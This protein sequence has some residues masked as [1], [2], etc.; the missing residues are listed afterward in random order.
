M[1]G[2]CSMSITVGYENPIKCCLL[3][4]VAREYDSRDT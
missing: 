3:F 4:V 1:R 2:H